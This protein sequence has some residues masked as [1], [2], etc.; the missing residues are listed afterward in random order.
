MDARTTALG[1]ER[2]T[3]WGRWGRRSAWATA[4]CLAL[5]L[6][7][8]RAASAAPPGAAGIDA[9]ASYP[10]PHDATDDRLD[11]RFA[12]PA[13]FRRVAV[14]AG[15][16]GAFV[17]SLPLRPVGT[18]VLDFQGGVQRAGDDEFVAA[19][20]DIDVG[21]ADLEQCADF[22][23]R[24]DAEWRYGRGERAIGYG[25]ASGA[26]LDYGAFL[27]RRG[28]G[29]AESHA[30][31]RRYLDAVF[32]AANTASLARE[33]RAVALDDVHPGDV[34][35]MTGVPFGHAVLVLDVAVGEGGRRALLLGQGFMPA[36]SFHVLRPGRADPWFVLDAHAPQVVTPFWRPFPAT[37]LR[38]LS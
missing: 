36:Q 1:G 5:A 29:R 22:V 24:L 37:A 32:A 18:P 33:G 35:V 27:R 26:R 12:A 13:G 11:Q 2:A 23:L 4:V 15:S 3:A 16:F 8:H 9:G 10:W 25:T 6:G 30:V 34:L 19:V 21:D 31:F 17:R 28:A 20:V 7:V 38:R 14:D